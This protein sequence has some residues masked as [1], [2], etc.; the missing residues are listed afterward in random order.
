MLEVSVQATTKLTIRLLCLCAH[1]H[2][3]KL[4]LDFSG[5]STFLRSNKLYVSCF[6]YA[7]Q[8][9]APTSLFLWRL[10]FIDE[11]AP[12]HNFWRFLPTTFTDC[13]KRSRSHIVTSHIITNTINVILSTFNSDVGPLCCRI[14]TS[15]LQ[16]ATIIENACLKSSCVTIARRTCSH[17]FVPRPNRYSNNYSWYTTT[18]SLPAAILQYGV[19]LGKGVNV[20]SDRSSLISAA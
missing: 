6:L 9:L 12:A 15:N 7:H 19:V 5:K 14:N 17:T 16:H 11:L 10:P 13:H 4:N 3:V 18:N 8:G 2:K 1:F 20:W